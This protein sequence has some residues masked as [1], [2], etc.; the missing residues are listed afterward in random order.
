MM[1]FVV[2]YDIPCS[3]RR[4]KVSDLLSGYGQRVQFSVFECPLELPKYQELKKRLRRRVH[5]T[6]DRIRIY[7]VSAHTLPQVELWGG[8]PLTQP[9]RSHIF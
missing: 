9:D 2:A 1:F 6:E 4:K 8:P 7:P 5:P 3:K